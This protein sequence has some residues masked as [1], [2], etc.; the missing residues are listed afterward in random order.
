MRQALALRPALELQVA[1]DGLEGLALAQREPFDLAIVDI[2]LPGIDGLELC[3]RLKAESATREL[4]LIAMSANAMRDDIH[5]AREAGFALYLTK[6][7]DV[8]QL[9][10]ELDRLLAGAAAAAAPAPLS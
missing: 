6:P 5:R 4:P 10:A 2:G 1:S 3:R 8:P 9:L 7:I